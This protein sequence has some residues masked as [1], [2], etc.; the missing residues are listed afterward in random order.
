MTSIIF[1]LIAAKRQSC[2]GRNVRRKSVCSVGL[3]T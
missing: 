2:Q 3:V 1:M